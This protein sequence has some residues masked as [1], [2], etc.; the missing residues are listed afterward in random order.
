[1]MARQTD[2]RVNLD[3]AERKGRAEEGREEYAGVQ[4]SLS[5]SR[6]ISPVW[7]E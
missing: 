2:W 6:Q 1:M 4:A 7:E 3:G 5:R